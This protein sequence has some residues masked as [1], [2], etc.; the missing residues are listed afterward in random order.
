M[1]NVQTQGMDHPVSTVKLEPSEKVV[2][3]CSTW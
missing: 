2:L 1:A 3:C